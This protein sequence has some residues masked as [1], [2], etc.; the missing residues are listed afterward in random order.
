MAF[1]APKLYKV[2]D[3]TLE[4]LFVHH[5]NLRHNF[6]KSVFPASTFN[7]GP[8]TQCVEHIDT[9][10][11]CGVMSAGLFDPT[12]GGHIVVQ[13]PKLVIEFPPGSTVLLPS[14]TLKLTHSNITIQPD[15]M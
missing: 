7:L 11:L 12:K 15:E 3:D 4:E 5:R 13:Q 14:S 2:Y 1:Y 8:S 6:P 10:G 9:Y